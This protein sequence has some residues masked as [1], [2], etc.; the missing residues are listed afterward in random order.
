MLLRPDLDTARID[1]IESEPTLKMICDVIDPLSGERYTRDPRHVATKAEAHLAASGIADKA[2]FGPELEFFLFDNV[3]FGLKINS[4]FHVVDSDEAGLELGPRRGR[5]QHRL[6]D[7][8]QAGLLAH[9]AVRP[10]L[11]PSL[12][13][14]G[15]DG[16]AGHRVRGPSPRG[17]DGRPGRDRDPLQHA[18]Q[19]GGRDPV[20][21]ARRPQRGQGPRQVGDVHA[22]AP[23]RRQR[24]RHARPPVPVARGRASCSTTRTATRGCRSWPGTTSA[25]CSGTAPRCSPSVRRP[26]TPTSGWF[27][28]SRRRF[29]SPTPSATAPRPSA[30]PPTSSRR[31]SKRIEFRPPDPSANTY[32][33]FSAMMMAGLDGI[34]NR[35]DPGDPTDT[36]IY[37]LSAGGDREHPR[38]ADL[39]GGGGGSPRERSRLPAR[40]RGSSPRT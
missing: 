11:G 9:P 40:R 16:A 29:T 28:A 3:Q 34:R 7:P 32:L 12:G 15:E 21:Q 2:F 39:D 22:E 18:A 5:Q 10:A 25:A 24:H 19:Q 26:P 4:S 27:P 8:A 36:D 30:S 20:V 31:K 37:E 33:A 14:G 17:G 35:I 38:R 6:Q 23:V 1:P 13:D